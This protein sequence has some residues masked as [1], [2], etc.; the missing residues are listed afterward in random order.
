MSVVVKVGADPEFFL[1]KD[2]K[3]VSAH[4][5][6]PGSKHQPHLVDAGAIQLDGTAVEFNISPAS[7][8]IEFSTNINTVLNQLRTHIPSEYEFDF[9]PSVRYDAKYFEQVPE[10][11]KEL[12]CDPD[13]NAWKEGKVNPRPTPKGDYATLRTGAG[14][15][16]IG[17]GEKLDITHSDHITDCCVLV[18]Q[19]D[20]YFSFYEKLWDK[21]DTRRTLYGARGAFRPKHYGVEYRVLSNAWLKY[22]KMWPWLFD[23]VKAVFDFT[24]E[25]Q[26]VQSPNRWDYEYIAARYKH[27]DDASKANALVDYYHQYFNKKTFPKFSARFLEA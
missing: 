1:K 15:L 27:A 9:S 8:A 10:S 17:W 22:P 4:G 25:G 7:T 12:G 20:N 11:S 19:L 24:V 21:D 2:G 6:V 16:H 3:N 14:H 23:S 26:T 18:K 5:I 13:F